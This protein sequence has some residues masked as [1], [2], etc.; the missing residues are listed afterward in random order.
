MKTFPQHF[1][2]ASHVPAIH[3]RWPKCPEQK[4]NSGASRCCVPDFAGGGAIA[5]EDRFFNGVAKVHRFRPAAGL[6]IPA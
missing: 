3:P 4:R 6:L 5:I 1:I 2:R